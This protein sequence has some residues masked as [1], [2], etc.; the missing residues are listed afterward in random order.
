M[1]NPRIYLTRAWRALG[2]GALLLALG[3][4]AHAQNAKIDEVVQQAIKE[5][6]ND[7][8]VIIRYKTLRGHDRGK[9][10]LQRAKADLK[11]EI[12]PQRT[13]AGK[14]NRIQ[15]F[16][17]LN[18]AELDHISYDAPV[19]AS[20]VLSTTTSLVNDGVSVDASGAREARTRYGVTGAGVTV[21]VIDSGV[22]T[23][24]DVPGTRIKA[25]VDFV[26]GISQAYD[27]N[28]HGT[29]V[30]SLAAGVD[31]VCVGGWLSLLEIP[32]KYAGRVMNIHPALL[33]SFGGKGMLG[34]KVHQAVL[35][36]GVKVSGCTVH[37]VWEGVDEGP[38]IVQAAVPVLES[39]SPETL[40][41]RILTEEHR[42]YPV[43]VQLFADGR[44]Q[45]EGRRVHVAE[46]PRPR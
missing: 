7:F 26:N 4:P 46:A 43:A 12:R 45:V 2:L 14:L 27:D 34:R 8:E 32:R 22:Q 16:E 10:K 15:L 39:D 35:D 17:V 40:S 23:S 24:P 18:D 6:R 42:I 33:P 31:L 3:A 1:R 41:A 5:G 25:F 44:L 13:L 20:Q 38:I 19:Q 28:G 9:Q 30:A 21:A 37:F 29:H 36:A 11:H